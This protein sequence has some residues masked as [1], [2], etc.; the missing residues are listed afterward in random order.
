MGGD[1]R[2]GD[3]PSGGGQVLTI[4]GTRGLLLVAATDC[5][6]TAHTLLKT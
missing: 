2:T 4:S 1:D 5:S 3:D 6:A